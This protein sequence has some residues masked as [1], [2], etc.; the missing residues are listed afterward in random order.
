M[1]RKTT[2]KTS[3]TPSVFDTDDKVVSTPE[4]VEKSSNDK[5]KPQPKPEFEQQPD[6]FELIIERGEA[7]KLSPKS[8]GK[9]YFQLATNLDDKQ[10]YLRIIG[11]DGGGLHSKEWVSLEKVISTLSG[12]TDQ[13]FKSSALK[14]CMVGRSS[15]NFSFLAAV[16]RSSQV[17]LIT[18]A[19][20]S[21]FSHQLSPSFDKTSA[22]LLK[23]K[24]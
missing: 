7:N 2:S 12:L 23:K 22:E 17:N 13:V 11:N 24:P 14:S 3:A 18:A 20:G 9:I 1:N 8:Q 19:E 5:V 6:R 10:N 21:P 16:L 4:S 15:N